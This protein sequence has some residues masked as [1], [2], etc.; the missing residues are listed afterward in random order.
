M[1]QG[2]RYRGGSGFW[3][4]AFCGDIFVASIMGETSA[5]QQLHSPILPLGDRPGYLVIWGP[6]AEL[7][8]SWRRGGLGNEACLAASQCGWHCTMGGC[9]RVPS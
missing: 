2:T 9:V 3:S 7:T 8:R 6:H 5:E 1:A 4:Q